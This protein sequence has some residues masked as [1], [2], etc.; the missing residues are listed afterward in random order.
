MKQVLFIGGSADGRTMFVEDDHVPIR[1]VKGRIEG[2]M[3]KS[4]ELIDTTQMER[5]EYHPQYL[6]GP[7]SKYTIYCPEGWGGDDMVTAL[8]SGYVSKEQ[9][10]CLSHFK[11]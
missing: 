3:Y 8:F 11:N 1:M 2:G 7:S 10:K 4:G 5:E 9:R 6:H